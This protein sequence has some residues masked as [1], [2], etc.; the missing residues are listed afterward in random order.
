MIQ[1]LFTMSVSQFLAN[2][3]FCM[4]KKCSVSDHINQDTHL[5]C[6]FTFELYFSTTSET[7]MKRN[8]M[9]QLVLLQ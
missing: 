9:H 1:R 8:L 3:F 7:E 4:N 2:R 6:I 5:L